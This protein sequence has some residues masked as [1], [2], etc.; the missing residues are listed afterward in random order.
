MAWQSFR[1]NGLTSL[2]PVNYSVPPNTAVDS[3]LI[4][5]SLEE[6]LVTLTFLKF[7]L[8]APKCTPE[9]HANELRVLG[10]VNCVV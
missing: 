2:F 5:Y 8:R 7:S 3:N 4:T 10:Y 6:P 9:S 1:R